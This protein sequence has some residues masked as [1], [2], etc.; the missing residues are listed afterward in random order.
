[1]RASIAHCMCSLVFCIC[2]GCYFCHRRQPGA[3]NSF[4]ASVCASLR[5]WMQALLHKWNLHAM[6]TRSSPQ[7]HHHA[8]EVFYWPAGAAAEWH[9]S[10]ERALAPRQGEFIWFD[11]WCAAHIFTGACVVEPRAWFLLSLADTR[12]RLSRTSSGGHGEEGCPYAPWGSVR[13]HILLS[14]ISPPYL[15]G[16]VIWGCVCESVNDHD[17]RWREV[18]FWMDGYRLSDAAH[19]VRCSAVRRCFF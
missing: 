13:V 7:L 2:W 1:M 8:S 19:S 15:S 9:L 4:L 12:P 16:S 11:T 17:S 3:Q 14:Q 6:K 5:I 18:L 10:S